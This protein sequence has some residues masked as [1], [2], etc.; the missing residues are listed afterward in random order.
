[1]SQDLQTL[2]QKSVQLGETI[3]SLHQKAKPVDQP[4]APKPWQPSYNLYRHKNHLYIDIELPGVPSTS[5]SVTHGDHSLV[6]VKGMKPRPEGMLGIE[7]FVS[8]RIFGPFT[9]LFAAPLHTRLT[10]VDHVLQNGVL[11]IK[12]GLKAVPAKN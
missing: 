7:D 6:M 1:M 9:C 10:N 5:V 12:A 4:P 8:S 3:D 11:S 2:M